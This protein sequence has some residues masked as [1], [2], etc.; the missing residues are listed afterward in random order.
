[1]S[2]TIIQTKGK[3][4]EELVCPDLKIWLNE[5]QVKRRLELFDKFYQKQQEKIQSI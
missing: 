3:V 2:W 4:N 1:M 5:S